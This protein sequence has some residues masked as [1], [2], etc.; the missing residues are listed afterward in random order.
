MWNAR[1]QA[2]RATEQERAIRRMRRGALQ[3]EWE[4]V[5]EEYKARRRESAVAGGQPLRQR[6]RSWFERLIGKLRPRS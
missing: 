6:V 3:A 2:E 5:W 4:K 1:Y